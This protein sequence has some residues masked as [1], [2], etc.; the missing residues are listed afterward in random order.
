MIMIFGRLGHYGISETNMN[1]ETAIRNIEGKLE[2]IVSG[3]PDA[4]SQ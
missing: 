1:Q 4:T 3:K 2:S